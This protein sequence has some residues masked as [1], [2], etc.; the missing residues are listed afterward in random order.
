MFANRLLLSDTLSE[1][2]AELQ[3]TEVR[4]VIDSDHRVVELGGS[5]PEGIPD[6]DSEIDEDPSTQTAI[7]VH[8]DVLTLQRKVLRI[9]ESSLKPSNSQIPANTI[10]ESSSIHEVAPQDS[11]KEGTVTTSSSPPK[12]SD[13]EDISQTPGSGIYKHKPVILLS[14]YGEALRYLTR[15]AVLGR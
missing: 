3:D 14:Q 13:S 11:I 6:F 12:P 9:A 1:P 10:R 2:D 7:E 4:K 8:D 5:F 15:N